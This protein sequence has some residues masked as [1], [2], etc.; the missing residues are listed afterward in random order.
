MNIPSR[1]TPESEVE[2]Y[3][4]G[5]LAEISVAAVKAFMRFLITDLGAAVESSRRAM[6]NLYSNSCAL[7]GEELKSPAAETQNCRELA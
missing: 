2:L 3:L 4:D 5:A 1:T 7:A 6:G